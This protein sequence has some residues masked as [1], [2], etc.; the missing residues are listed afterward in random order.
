MCKQYLGKYFRANVSTVTKSNECFVLG[1]MKLR[2]AIRHLK[3]L[4][5]CVIFKSLVMQ[6]VVKG[7]LLLIRN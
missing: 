4:S 1:D 7:V 2:C 5:Y 3:Y 6:P